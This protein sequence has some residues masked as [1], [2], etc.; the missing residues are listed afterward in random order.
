M[1]IYSYINSAKEII[2]L[3]DG[4]IP[5]A[6]W[7]KIFFAAHKK[8]GSKDRKHIT[9]LCYSWFRL[10][11]SFTQNTFEERISISMLLTSATSNIYLQQLMPEWN[12]II[13]F[14]L[15]EK[16][17]FLN[18]TSELQKIFP[19]VAEL[20][21]E[22]EVE[23]FIMSHLKQPDVFLRIRPGNES[24]VKKKLEEAGTS[25]AFINNDT[26]VLP[27][28][29]KASEVLEIDKEVVVQDLSSQQ[30]L[31]PLQEAVPKDKIIKAWDCCAASGGK[32]LLLYDLFNNVQLT[33]SDIRNSI[34]RNLKA[35]FKSAGI[36]DYHSFVD[37]VSKEG[38]K[39]KQVYDLVICD[40]PCSGSGTWS[41]TPEQLVFFEENKIDYYQ[42][43]QKK[44]V[45]NASSAVKGGGYLL[46]ITCS[47]FTKENEDV[48]DHILQNTS[49]E[50]VH[51]QYF[52]GFEKRADTLYVALFRGK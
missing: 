10:G 29:S 5:F 37:D 40:A 17:E 30:V 32:S 52:K 11:K 47:V 27:S 39:A 46:Y 4:K 34:L 49:L 35:R 9:Q 43:L 38:F 18:A 13:E 50:C 2:S 21:P 28:N 45:S 1:H 48:V 41:R 26:L 33:V 22:I 19:W 31:N 51:K 24:E 12:E 15:Q 7:L 8:Y 42:K 14:S 6:A 16:L 3:Y 25:Y 20:S 23:E 36:N 44:I